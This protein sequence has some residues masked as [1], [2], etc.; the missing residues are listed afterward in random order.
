MKHGF[1]F[2]KYYPFHNGHK[3][4]I[5]F[6]LTQCDI[7]FIVVCASD[8]ELINAE[9]R[10]EWIRE[11][12]SGN[13]NIRYIELNYSESELPNSSA[14]SKTISKIWSGKFSEILP[15]M[16]V[17]ITSEKYGDYVAECMNIQHLCFDEDRKQLPISATEIR[18]DLYANWAF[19]PSAV[20]RYFQKK[21]FFLGTESTGKSMLSERIHQELN[22]SLVSEVGRDL[23]PHSDTFS[24]S[25][26]ENVAQTHAKN[27]KTA[28]NERKPFVLVDTD[29][30]TTLS[31]S[32]LEFGNYFAVSEEIFKANNADKRF[33]LTKECPYVQDGTR[34]SEERRNALDQF[35]RN[36]LKE[37][38]IPFTEISGN[39]E[40]RITRIK[41]IILTNPFD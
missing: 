27:I 17:L 7:L 24:K 2:G 11:T 20:Q 1:V 41:E 6:S 14:S 40:E 23:I 25:D 8:L 38:N 16:D 18:A 32:K 31:Y 15:Q 13:K 9:T 26:L 3:A 33:Y 10:T 29:I 30:Y 22:A 5:D 4:L 19:I 39:W 12:Y 34:L 21:V 36:T 28:I 37:F 35:Q